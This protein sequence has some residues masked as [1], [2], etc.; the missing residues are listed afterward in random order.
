M[1]T[2]RQ[3]RANVEAIHVYQ[4]SAPRLGRSQLARLEQ[5]SAPL[6]TLLSSAE[7]LMNLRSTLPLHL[8]ASLAAGELIV[9]SKRLAI[10]ASN[11]LFAHVHVADSAAPADLLHAACTALSR[12]RL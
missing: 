8:Y 2:L 11:Q 6:V 4:R 12:H 1:T 9:S 5:A 10:I 3:R 7:V